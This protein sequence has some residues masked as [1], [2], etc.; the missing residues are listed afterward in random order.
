M[1]NNESGFFILDKFLCIITC[2]ILITKQLILYGYYKE[3]LL[4]GRLAWDE[5]V[6]NV[7]INW[8]YIMIKQTCKITFD[9]IKLYINF[10]SGPHSR[11]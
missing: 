2:F 8:V 4:T 9:I 11:Q 10:S 1:A 6:N 3:N 5:R 7:V